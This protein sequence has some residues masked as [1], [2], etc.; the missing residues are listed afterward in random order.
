MEIRY[1]RRE[2]EEKDPAHL[3]EQRR[4]IQ[5]LSRAPSQCFPRR[6]RTTIQDVLIKH[7]VGM[8]DELEVAFEW[9]DRKKKSVSSTSF[10]RGACGKVD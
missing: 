3:D 4:R 7:E 1:E 9:T 8:L 2:G 6:D 10:A 5:R